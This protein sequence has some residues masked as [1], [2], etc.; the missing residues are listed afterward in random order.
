VIKRVAGIDASGRCLLT[1]AVAVLAVVTALLV[2]NGAGPQQAVAQTAPETEALECKAGLVLSAG[3]SCFYPDTKEPFVVNSN[4]QARFL[5]LRSTE[6]IEAPAFRVSGRRWV[7]SAKAQGDGCW[8]IET[9]GEPQ[10]SATQPGDLKALSLSCLDIGQFDPIRTSYQAIWNAAVRQTTVEAQAA[11]ET[12]TVVIYPTDADDDPSN[13]HQIN[14]FADPPSPMI[15]A[16]I[17]T[18][19]SSSGDFSLYRIALPNR[20]PNAF[21]SAAL[22]ELSQDGVLT[23]CAFSADID[24]DGFCGDD[25]IDRK[26][27]AVWIVRMLDG[28][29]PAAVTETRF[30]DVEELPASWWPFIERLAELGHTTG[31]GDG[32]DYCGDRTIT[33]A[34]LA[35]FLSRAFDLPAGP[36][37][38]FADVAADDWYADHVAALKASGITAG[39]GDG[40]NFCGSDITT[41]AQMATFLHRAKALT[42]SKQ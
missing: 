8:L 41:R 25:P 29:D 33:R 31:C 16:V 32:S 13:G 5:Y 7:L 11:N 40:T 3:E 35:V 6:S 12:T 26:T 27:V 19:V 15:P 4:G 36:N 37:P 24:A 42:N 2:H 34:E 18:V 9:V 23:G 21:Y 17:V 20:T 39:C 14:L 22:Q 38:N 28:K 1:A 30:G 10:N